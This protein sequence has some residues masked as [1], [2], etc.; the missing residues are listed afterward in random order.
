M[1]DGCYNVGG[2]ISATAGNTT[3]KS[4]N[5]TNQ[6]EIFLWLFFSFSLTTTAATIRKD[7]LLWA[8]SAILANDKV[9]PKLIK[10][11]CLLYSETSFITGKDKLT[12]LNRELSPNI[13]RLD[14]SGIFKCYFL[15]DDTNSEFSFLWDIKNLKI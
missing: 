5:D 4:A 12:L 15:L 9:K 7:L 8:D 2:L 14:L 13:I 6:D 1:Q 11:F 3:W 10:S